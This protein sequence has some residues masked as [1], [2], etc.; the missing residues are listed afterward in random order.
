MHP[1]VFH[2]RLRD[3]ELQTE[4]RIDAALMTRPVVIISSHH[5]NGTVI[6]ISKEAEAEGIQKGMK[7]SLVRQMN[8]GVR[9]LPYNA[10]LYGRIH[11]YIHKIVQR[12]TPLVE[13]SGYGK[14][15][16]D[17][18]GMN[19]IYSS[20]E[21]VGAQI[22]NMVRD[23]V[24]LSTYL[25][26]S[27]N[28]LISRIST[29]V[30]S[31]PIHRIITGDEAKFLS[32]LNS[33]VIPTVH[34]PSV[35]KLVQ[36]LIL[37]QVHHIQSVVDRTADARRLFGK[38]ALSLTREVRGQDMSVVRSPLLKDHI[39]KQAVMKEDTNDTTKIYFELKHVAEA[40]AFQL[41][42]R[43]QV[44]KSVRL[45]IHYT[46]GFKFEAQGSCMKYNDIFVLDT[47]WHI[48]EKANHRRNRIRSILVDISQFI[49]VSNQM[50][51]FKEDTKRDRISTAVDILR[52]KYKDINFTHN[53]GDAHVSHHFI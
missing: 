39:L 49:Y 5:Q 36:F 32:P 17:M 44:A 40:I 30:I 3:F 12:F 34:Q 18:T 31:D 43:S 13:P 38:H 11:E 51:L 10:S 47:I 50:E 29:S 20:D 2:L 52:K 35:R 4:R 33:P 15:Y 53:F 25:G 14:F 19:R 16:M 22:S 27:Q 26:I 41:R 21:Q 9:I 6:A 8:H 46:D 42:K 28:K 48:F 45:E 7:V 1:T 37:R 23:Q 24:G